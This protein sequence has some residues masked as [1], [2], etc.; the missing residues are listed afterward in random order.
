MIICPYDTCIS[1]LDGGC[2]RTDVVLEIADQ[3]TETLK[4]MSYKKDE[5]KVEE[6]D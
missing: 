6:D 5:R 1:N 3:E 2:I 4:C